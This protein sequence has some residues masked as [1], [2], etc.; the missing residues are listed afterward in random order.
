M[1]RWIR[2]QRLLELGTPEIS[3]VERTLG[4]SPIESTLGVSPVE[5]PSGAFSVKGPSGLSPVRGPPEPSPQRL[6][7]RLPPL[8]LNAQQRPTEQRIPVST[9]FAHDA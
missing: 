6:S 7:I 1:Q 9:L 4:I 8:M 5:G 3:P 2:D